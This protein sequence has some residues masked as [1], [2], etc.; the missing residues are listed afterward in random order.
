MHESGASS[1]NHALPDSVEHSPNFTV[2]AV[3]GCAAC[4]CPHGFVSRGTAVP[5]SPTENTFPRWLG[6]TVNNCLLKTQTRQTYSA[7]TV[8]RP[9]PPPLPLLQ[10]IEEVG[11]LRSLNAYLCICVLSLKVNNPKQAPTAFNDPCKPSGTLGLSAQP[12][13]IQT[14]TPQPPTEPHNLRRPSTP[15]TLGP[16]P[17]TLNRLHPLA[18]SRGVRCPKRILYRSQHLSISTTTATIPPVLS[19]EHWVGYW[20]PAFHLKRPVCHAT[21]T[22]VAAECLFLNSLLL[23]ALVVYFAFMC[24][25][26]WGMMHK[27]VFLLF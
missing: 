16:H 12:S 22:P 14:N 21:A 2:K 25:S 7:S 8:T 10:M 5:L 23:I 11:G 6:R 13:R 18:V 17:T 24:P 27:P 3:T 9:P 4:R 15:P 1:T 20:Q 26:T 19:P